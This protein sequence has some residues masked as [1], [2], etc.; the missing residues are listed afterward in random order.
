MKFSPKCNTESDI[1]KF[2]I[3]FGNFCL[4][5]GKTGA[6]YRPQICLRKIPAV[7]FQNNPKH[8]N[9]SYKMDLD[10]CDHCIIAKFHETDLVIC[11]RSREGITLLYKYGSLPRFQKNR[12][13]LLGNSFSVAGRSKRDS[14]LG[15]SPP[16]CPDM[17]EILLKR[18]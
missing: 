7:S 18:K 12:H 13:L 10:L 9:L 14:N 16:Y 4:N 1:S 11:S 3:K 15:S 2:A 6:D 5:L 17:N 8:L